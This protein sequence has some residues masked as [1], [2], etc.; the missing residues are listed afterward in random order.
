MRKRETKDEFAYSKRQRNPF[1]ASFD[2]LES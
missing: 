2:G 1:D